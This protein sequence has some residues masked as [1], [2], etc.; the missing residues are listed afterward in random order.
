MQPKI[1]P[2][3]KNISK[4][5][6]DAYGKR[7]YQ[8]ALPSQY[9]GARPRYVAKR[10]Y[11]RK[12]LD[13]D[14]SDASLINTMSFHNLV[15]LA[16][17]TGESQRV[18]RKVTVD[19]IQGQIQVSMPAATAAGSTATLFRY[20][21]VLDTQTNKAQFA[22]TDLLTAD[23]FW[24]F[25]NLDNNERFRILKK[26]TVSL[27]EQGATPSGAAYT[28]NEI[29]RYFTFNIKCKHVIDYVGQD[30]TIDEQTQ[31]SL[32]LVYQATNAEQLV[33]DG[34]VRIRYSDS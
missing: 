4:Y 11:E 5:K 27:V 26:K 20:M 17:G 13:V 12:F 30:G 1:S 24:S 3:A 28:F 32:C 31:N 34:T 22:A 6:T 21:L 2:Y 16:Q 9:R 8:Y 7:T 33:L 29:I 25:N 15:T 10:S 14:V 19:S 18:G 23:N